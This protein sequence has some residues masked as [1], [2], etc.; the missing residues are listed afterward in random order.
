MAKSSH[1][2]SESSQR[3]YQISEFLKKKLGES[4]IER[5]ELKKKFEASQKKMKEMSL[6][7]EISNGDN[8]QLLEK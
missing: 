1:E 2:F 3:N 7:L 4:E 6:K 8:F 5:E